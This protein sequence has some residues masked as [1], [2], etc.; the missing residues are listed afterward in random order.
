MA[1]VVEVQWS[2][3]DFLVNTAQVERVD[4]C[5][6]HGAVIWMNEAHGWA[7][8]P[9]WINV[10]TGKKF[11]RGIFTHWMPVPAGPEDER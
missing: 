5:G 9:E 3:N 1:M 2:G 8:D 6:A 10:Y 11:P 4:D 7:T